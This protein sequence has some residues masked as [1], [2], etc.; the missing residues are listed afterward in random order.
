MFS[1]AFG[2]EEQECHFSSSPVYQS[3]SSS[4]ARLNASIMEHWNRMSRSGRCPIH[5]YIQVQGGRGSEQSDLA[6]LASV[7]YGGVE[8]DGL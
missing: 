5:E 1:G 8:L 2:W 7:Q 3:S 6:V 4:M